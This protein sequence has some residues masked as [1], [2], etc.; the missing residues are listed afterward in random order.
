MVAN[1]IKMTILFMLLAICIAC[2]A[3]SKWDRM[4]T[5][6]K[7]SD[8]ANSPDPKSPSAVSIESSLKF[9]KNMRRSDASAEPDIE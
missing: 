6:N 4:Q 3:Y 8:V 9:G 7:T 1:V 2:A 5:N